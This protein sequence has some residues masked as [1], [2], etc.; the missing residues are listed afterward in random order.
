MKNAFNAKNMQKI[1]FDYNGIIKCMRRIYTAQF[2]IA[3]RY[4]D[5]KKTKYF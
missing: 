5:R 4:T 2:N 3:Y 1:L